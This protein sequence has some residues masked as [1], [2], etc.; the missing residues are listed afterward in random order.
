MRT[1]DEIYAALKEDFFQAGGLSLAEGGDMSLRLMAVVAEIFTLEAQCD[2]SARQAFPQFA[3]GDYLDKHAQIRALERKQASKAQGLLR[4]YTAEKAATELTVPQGTQCLD[5]Q[6]R[7]FVTLEEVQIPQGGDSCTAAAQAEEAGEQGNVSAGSIV[8]IRLTPPGIAGVENPGAF[9]GGSA[10]EEDQELRR[11]VLASYRRLPNGANAAYYEAVVLDTEG[12]EKVVVLPRER[13]R[14]T[15]DVVFSAAGGLPSQE[16]IDRVQQLL[17]K[18]REICVDV[19]VRAPDIQQIDIDAQLSIAEG[20]D[21]GRVAQQVRESLNQYFGG[22][23]LGQ[24]V[25]A[26]RLLATIM[27]VEGVENCRLVKPAGDTEAAKTGLPVA[28]SISI[29][30]VG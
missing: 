9:S 7:V 24:A 6:G 4:F 14:G 3:A 13:G 19:L 12:V 18:Q 30:E 28:G 25:Y 17:D 23:R 11:R 20:Y 16:L 2:F 1:I 15:V 27:G 8:F 10:Q 5:A 22:H 21:F 29:S 26:S